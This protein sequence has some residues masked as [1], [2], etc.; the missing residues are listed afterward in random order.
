[1][2]TVCSLPGCRVVPG[3]HQCRELEQESSLDRPEEICSIQP[4]RECRDIAVR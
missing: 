3:P 1:M 2:R 4:R